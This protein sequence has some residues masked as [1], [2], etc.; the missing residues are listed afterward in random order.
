[1]LESEDGFPQAVAEQLRQTVFR[2]FAEP[3]RGISV[4]DKVPSSKEEMESTIANLAILQVDFSLVISMVGVNLEKWLMVLPEER[5]KDVSTHMGNIVTAEFQD[6]GRMFQ[7][8]PFFENDFPRHTVRVFQNELMFL[9]P[10]DVNIPRTTESYPF[11]CIQH[12]SEL[13]KS[14]LF[15]ESSRSLAP[16]TTDHVS[17]SLIANTRQADFAES[18][19]PHDRSIRSRHAKVSGEIVRKRRG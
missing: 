1:M 17:V 7:V 4:I 16:I 3:D 2:P 9:C 12:E 14:P 5:R 15:P 18:R 19:Y 13:E 6:C 11:Y 8:Q 10:P